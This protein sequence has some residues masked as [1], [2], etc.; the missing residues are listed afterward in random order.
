MNTRANQLTREEV[1]GIVGQLD[2]L[3]QLTAPLEA[4]GTAGAASQACAAVAQLRDDQNYSPTHQIPFV[5]VK[6]AGLLTEWNGMATGT[7]GYSFRI[8]S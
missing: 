3:Q 5:T 6:E 2:P 8:E 1:A 4:G 7:Y